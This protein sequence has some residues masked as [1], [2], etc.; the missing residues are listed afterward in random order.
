MFQSFGVIPIG[1]KYCGIRFCHSCLQVSRSS[2]CGVRPARLARS[3]TAWLWYWTAREFLGNCSI[4]A[5]DIDDGALAKAKEGRYLERSLKDVPEQVASKYFKPDGAMYRIDDRLK[6][7][8][9][10]Q[11]QN[12]LLD[13]F[14]DGY[15]L[16]ICRNVMIYFTEEAKHKLYQK[17]AASLRP[18]G[19]L[20]VGSTEQIF[21]P[22][23]Y[24]LESTET[25]FLS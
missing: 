8:V 5:S 21:S 14:E 24:G 12:L 10:F 7:A 23:Q 4:T 6:Q 15:D 1:G 22:N 25:F 2:S 9:K 11:K 18:G 17:F 16:I 13:R 3:R 20:F 19:V